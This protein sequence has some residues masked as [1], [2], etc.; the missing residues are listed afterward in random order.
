[1]LGAVLCQSSRTYIQNI[2]FTDISRITNIQA[3]LE[4]KKNFVKYLYINYIISN[5]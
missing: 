4:S 5:R 1:M 3:V 2:S